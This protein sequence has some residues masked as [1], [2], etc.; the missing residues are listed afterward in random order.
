MGSLQTYKQIKHLGLSIYKG[1]I[2]DNI[3]PIVIMRFFV[4]G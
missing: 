3:L 4:V 2:F 1:Q